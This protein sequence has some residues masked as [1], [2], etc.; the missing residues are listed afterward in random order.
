MMLAG[1]LSASTKLSV[2]YLATLYVGYIN[3]SPPRNRASA[4]AIYL[5]TKQSTDSFLDTV[6]VWLDNP[7]VALVYKPK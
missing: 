1:N 7:F 3:Q 4:L 2:E 6:I 5:P